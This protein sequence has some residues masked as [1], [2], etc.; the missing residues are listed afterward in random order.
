MAHAIMHL[1]TATAAAAAASAASIYPSMDS[2]PYMMMI[3][4]LASWSCCCSLLAVYLERGMS[5][6]LLA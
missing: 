3:P 2:L 4:T 1:L 5:R 6:L